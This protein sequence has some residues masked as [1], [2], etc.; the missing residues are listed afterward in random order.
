MSEMHYR[1]LEIRPGH[2]DDKEKRLSLAFVSEEPVRREFGYEVI[3]QGQMD[4]SF[5]E[6]GRAPLLWMHDAEQVLGVVESVE[7]G[8]DR[9]SRAVVRLGKS[10]DLQRETTEQIEDG[11]ISNVSVGY[12]IT[13]MDETEE[14]IDGIPVFRVQTFPQEISLVSV[15]ADKSVGVGRHQE[16]PIAKEITM[17]QTVEQTMVRSVV[18]ENDPVVDVDAL[19]RAHEQA[20]EERAKTNKEIISLAVR[21]NQRQLAD[22]AIGK[23]MSLESFRGVLLNAIYTKPLDAGAEPVQKP[24]NEKRNYSFLRALNAASRGD[25]SG[26]GFE[27]EMSAEVAHKRNKQPQ[28]F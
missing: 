21:H 10:T 23:N 26:A 13:G 3:D 18:E 1:T 4:L 11:I 8:S 24:A 7:L 25:W 20:L 9:K 19:K 28:G 12:T 16:T 27:A 15:P 2:Y 6:S 5:M 22:E 14:K 17:E